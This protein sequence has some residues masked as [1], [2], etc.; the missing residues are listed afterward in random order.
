MRW[1][2]LT[3]LITAALIGV[4]LWRH[5]ALSLGDSTQEP[6]SSSNNT[7]GS[8]HRTAKPPR[9][10]APNAPADIVHLSARS[11]TVRAVLREVVRLPERDRR[12]VRQ[13]EV[14]RTTT[15]GR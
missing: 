13:S 11:E 10:R 14:E 3:G 7:F 12:I 1:V 6:N 4:I 2:S 8:Q 5:L 9:Q 15:D